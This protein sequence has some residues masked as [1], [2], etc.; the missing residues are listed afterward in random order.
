MHLSA[1]LT[2]VPRADTGWVGLT[3]VACVTHEKLPS[4]GRASRQLICAHSMTFFLFNCSRLLAF[5][6]T[7]L[8]VY[9]F[10]CDCGKNGTKLLMGLSKLL[11]STM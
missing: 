9:L 6:K 8:H 10:Q 1:K 5:E 4:R 3:S 11:V 2:L 7:T